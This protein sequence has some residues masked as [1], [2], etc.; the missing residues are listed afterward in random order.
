MDPFDKSVLE[1]VKP[2]KYR[3]CNGGLPA[4]VDANLTS[5]FIVN[6][7]LSAY[8]V[9]EKSQLRCCYKIFWRVEPKEDESDKK[10]KYSG[11]CVVFNNS[12][13][14]AEE[15]VMVKCYLNTSLIYTDMFAFVPLTNV[16]KV[17]DPLPLNVLVL[18][19][20]AV[21]RLNLHRQLPHTLKYLRKL[22][23]VELLGYNKVGD[24]TFPNLIPV[25][26]GYSEDELTKVCWHKNTDK[27]DKCPFIWKQYSEN[28]F[29]TAYAEDSAWMGIF[30]YA[31][32]GFHEQP[33]NYYWSFFNRIAEDIIGNEHDS[34]VIRCVGARRVY[35]TM[36]DY[37]KKFTTTMQN[38]KQPYFGFFWEVS[39]SHDYLNAPKMADEEFEAFFK[40]LNDS[41]ALN[42]T[43]LIFMSDHG[44]RWGGIR[45]TFQGRMEERL[46]FLTLLFPRWYQKTYH[47]AFINLQRNVRSLTTPYDLH[48]TLKDLMNPFELTTENLNVRTNFSRGYSLFAKIPYNR[49]CEDAAIASHFCTCQLSFPINK[50]EAV[51]IE[52]AEFAVDYI[53]SLLE[54]YAECSNLSLAA[55]H[56]ARALMHNETVVDKYKEYE[57]YMITL[58]TQPGGGVFEVTV[59]KHL[60]AKNTDIFEITGT[61]SRINLYGKQSKCVTD[62]HMKLYCYC[63]YLLK[64]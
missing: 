9:S 35:A 17:E 48:E 34:N 20:D 26:T 37:I 12:V 46:P 61:V 8:N 59:R 49:T 50:N 31:K 4:L 52:A 15:Y 41:G 43:A 39:L 18:G 56:N 53:N 51:V 40:Y 44:I 42:H 47:T 62:F 3:I 25:L 6:N 55:V 2:M 14:I 23:L 57:D 7:S 32:R 38:N 1:Y 45:S 22:G 28:G 5:L 36:L 60:N 63:K 21:S 33:T 19:I 29:K 54:W 16:S 13:E 10:V 58:E 24:N 64:T 30:N 27:F 11:E